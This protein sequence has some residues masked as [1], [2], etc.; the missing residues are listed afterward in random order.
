M[1]SIVN[2]LLHSAEPAVRFKVVT[3]AF[4]RESNSPQ[5]IRLRSV[6]PSANLRAI[7][8]RNRPNSR[9]RREAQ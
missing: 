4:G 3:N 8:L 7:F 5:A 9:P 6:R 1:D 2:R